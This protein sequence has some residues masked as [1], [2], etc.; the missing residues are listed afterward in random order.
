MPRDRLAAAASWLFILIA[1]AFMVGLM[2][3]EHDLG[4]VPLVAPATTRPAGREGADR[5]KRA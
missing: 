2:M 4:L 5:Q 1:M 3:A